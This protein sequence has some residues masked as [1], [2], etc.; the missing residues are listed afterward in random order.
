MY[1][2]LRV[3]HN[4]DQF[5]KAYNYM[6][7]Y[8]GNA[9]KLEFPEFYKRV[10]EIYMIADE[11]YYYGAGYICHKVWTNYEQPAMFNR[12]NN[13]VFTLDVIIFSDDSIYNKI[14]D[15]V[16]TII[17]DSNDRIIMVENIGNKATEIIN[18]LKNNKFK[19]N[20][21]AD[22]Y[23]TQSWYY[24]PEG[25]LNDKDDLRKINP[26]D[27]LYTI[28]KMVDF[29]CNAHKDYSDLVDQYTKDLLA[30]NIEEIQQSSS[31]NPDYQTIE[32]F[33]GTNECC[34]DCSC[35]EFYKKHGP[36]TQRYPTTPVGCVYNSNSGG[37]SGYLFNNVKHI[38]YVNP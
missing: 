14:Y 31:C 7:A 21:V 27:D 25:Y 19:R 16:R 6:K 34:H 37:G 30:R 26:R 24:I 20:K 13:N 11:C 3:P 22:R 5:K 2:I 36:F 1:E 12:Y 33:L 23:F 10:K 9:L 28:D 29:N 15:L 18:A 32:E 38:K 35:C 8:C 17:R 4:E